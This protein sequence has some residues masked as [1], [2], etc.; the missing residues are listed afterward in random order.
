MWL[1]LPQFLDLALFGSISF[2]GILTGKFKPSKKEAICPGICRDSECMARKHRISLHPETF[3]RGINHAIGNQQQPVG[4]IAKVRPFLF[5]ANLVLSQW[6]P[7]ETSGDSNLQWRLLQ[8][9]GSYPYVHSAYITENYRSSL[10]Y[11]SLQIFRC[12]KKKNR[13]LIP[14]PRIYKYRENWWGRTD[15]SFYLRL[16]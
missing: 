7:V 11:P 5:A 12:Q 4:F 16:H 2:A 6:D 14:L 15:I 9:F 3:F 10:I 1:D 8:V 13:L